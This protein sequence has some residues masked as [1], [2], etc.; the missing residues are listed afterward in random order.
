MA[1]A[2]HASSAIE[3]NLRKSE[4]EMQITVNHLLKSGSP[5]DIY[6]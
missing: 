5:P 2:L 3:Y 1:K 4:T 6:E